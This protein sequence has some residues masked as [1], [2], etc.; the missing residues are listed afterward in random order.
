VGKN[1]R[2]RKERC[3]ERRLTPDER[4]QRE[5]ERWRN[6]RSLILADVMAV[7]QAEAECPELGIGFGRKWTEQEIKTVAAAIE[8]RFIR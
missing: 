3:E 1:S 2:L 6:D 4:I 7:A 5:L 8:Q